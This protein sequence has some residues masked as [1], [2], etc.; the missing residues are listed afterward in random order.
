MALYTSNLYGKI[1]ITDESVRTVAGAA[2]LESYGVDRLAGISHAKGG[3]T[4][5]NFK[6]SVRIDTRDNR[7]YI[8]INVILKY[9]VSVDATV[10]SLRGAIKYNVGLFSGMPVEVININ[11]LGIE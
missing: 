1:L 3:H 11:V 10:E 2:A 8:E 5:K 7:I 6:R 4:R 9:G